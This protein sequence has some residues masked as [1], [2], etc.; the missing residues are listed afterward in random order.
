MSVDSK[1][2]TT[3]EVID[4]KRSNLLVS[5]R[6]QCDVL[7]ILCILITGLLLAGCGS[8]GYGTDSS[9]GGTTVKTDPSFANDIQ[10]IFNRRGCTGSSCHGSSVQAGLDLRTGSAYSSVVNVSSSE[11]SFLRVKPNNPDSSYL[12]MKVEGIQTV[13]GRMPLNLPALNSTDLQ[14]LRNWINQGA[15]QN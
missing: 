10:E 4:M 5:S 15:K 11:T 2:V 6:I 9:G 3:S 8:G 1:N 7:Y 13:G 14:N 12:I